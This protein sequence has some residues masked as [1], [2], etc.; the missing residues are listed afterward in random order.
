MRFVLRVWD[1]KGTL[2]SV[3]QGQL[4]DVDARR[5]SPRTVIDAALPLI[6]VNA[7]MCLRS[8]NSE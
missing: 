3:I 8:S 5:A 7:D 1:A 4:Y 6:D 2:T